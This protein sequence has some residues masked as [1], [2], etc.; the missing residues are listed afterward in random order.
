M[1]PIRPQSAAEAA[2]VEQLG[3]HFEYRIARPGTSRIAN[4][5]CG[6]RHYRE[7][8]MDED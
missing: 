3:A 5:I 8:E 1:D 6:L 7:P 4:G 2:S